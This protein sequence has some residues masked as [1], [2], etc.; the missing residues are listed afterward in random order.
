MKARRDRIAREEIFDAR[1]RED[2]P[3]VGDDVEDTAMID[4]IKTT[5]IPEVMHTMSEREIYVLDRRFVKGMTFEE[6]AKEHGVTRER[7]RQIEAKAL[8][9]LRHPS[10]L[11]MLSPKYVGTRDEILKIYDHASSERALE[12]TDGRRTK[13]G[14]VV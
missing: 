7:I 11:N 6:I 2:I 4:L 14:Y 3:L 8:R 13:P 12:Y 1:R 5:L 9:K 10:R